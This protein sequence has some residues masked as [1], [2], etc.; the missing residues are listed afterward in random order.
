MIITERVAK[1]GYEQ[2]YEMAKKRMETVE[3][4]VKARVEAE[5]AKEKED[6]NRIIETSSVVVEKE[7]PDEEPV[8]EV[9][10]EENPQE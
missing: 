1:A 7:V 8:A 6:L 4:E 10:A 2:F 3:A 9:P 5:V